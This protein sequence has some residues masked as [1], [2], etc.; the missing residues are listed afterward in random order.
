[1][2]AA[3]VT[4]ILRVFA[5]RP[6]G[7]RSSMYDQL[8]SWDNLLL[9]Y[10]RA[11]RGKRGHPN[12]AAFE[13]ALEDNLLKLQTELQI[14]AY[15]PGPYT[16]FHIHEP[17]RRLIS[18]APFRDRV[19]HH[20]L[21]N[22]IEPIYERSFIFDSYANR[23]GKGM[24]RALDR[25]QYFARRYPYV[26]ACD[27]RQFFPSIDHA[28]LREQLSRKISDPA[29]LWLVDQ[30]LASG[31]GVLREAYEPVYFPGVEGS[32][33]EPAG[34]PAADHACRRLPAPGG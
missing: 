8:C 12:V 10:R 15:Q 14:F 17:K 25:A 2:R 28:I 13:Y 20:A 29:V 11:S 26:L 1:M 22:L 6:K 9:A 31:A 18:A 24:H 33:S 21:C 16:S 3:T 34:W 19:V 5:K 32:C 23:V 27:V 30:I 7:Q 4:E